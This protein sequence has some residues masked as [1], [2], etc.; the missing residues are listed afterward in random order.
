MASVGVQRLEFE[1]LWPTWGQPRFR[2][3]PSQCGAASAAAA[4][5]TG[6]SCPAS[7]SSSGRS[8]S[9]QAAAARWSASSSASRYSGSTAN[10]PGPRALGSIDRGPRCDLAGVP[11]RQ[12][13]IS[14]DCHSAARGLTGR[15][16]PSGCRA[17]RRRGGGRAAGTRSPTAPPSGLPPCRL[18]TAVA[19]GRRPRPGWQPPPCPPAAS[20]R[21]PPRLPPHAAL[22]SVVAAAGRRAGRSA[23]AAAAS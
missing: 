8:V 3:T 9:P 15:R 11:A 23:A 1:R 7:C 4:A 2:S 21:L 22:H 18:R 14:A 16:R 13:A 20:P 6:G 5:S 10:R 17:S 12:W 19:S